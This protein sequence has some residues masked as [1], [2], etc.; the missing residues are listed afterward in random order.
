MPELRAAIVALRRTFLTAGLFSL[1]INALMLVPSLY[2]L[3]VYDRVLTSRNEMTLLMVTLVM[4]LAYALLGIFEWVRAQLLIGASNQL[5]DQVG[6]R[7][8]TATFQ[9]TLRG[10]NGNPAQS[11]TDLSTVRQFLSGAGLLAFFDA[12]WM[13]I[14]LIVLTLL[15]PLLGLLALVGG[16]VLII[17]TFITERI[18]QEPLSQANTLA[19]QANT[20]AGNSLRNAE[21]I[22]AM[23]MLGALRAHWRRRHEKSLALQ[24]LASSRAGSIGAVTRFTRISLQ[25]LALGLGAWLVVKDELGAGS[26]IVASILTGRALSPIEQVIGAWRN[27]VGARSAYDRLSTLLK[28]FPAVAPAMPLPRPVGAVSVEAVSAVAPNTQTVI[29]RGINFSVAPAEIVA[30]IGPSASGKSSLARLLVGVWPAAAGKVRLD[31]ADIHAWNKLELGRHVG[32]LPQDVELFEGSV[33][34]NIARFNTP[35]SEATVQAAQ[36]AGIHDMILRLPKGYE[37]E[38]GIGG[39]HLSGGQRQRIGLARA[40]YGDPA[41]VVLD[42]PNANLDETGE[43]AL[44][45]AM[46]DLTAGG[47][48]V[49]VVAHRSN[50]VAVADKLLVLRDGMQHAFGPRADVIG[51]LNRAAQAAA[52]AKGAPEPASAATPS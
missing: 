8:F 28:N 6:N 51:A 44:V 20:F 1:F 49:L 43:L 45:K 26:M 38:I 39:S 31:G 7:V 11:L 25:S 24:Q 30:I 52:A 13:P 34:D 27:L 9:A 12:P 10:A 18:T 2:M 35:D 3:Q 16:I 47:S 50:I 36:R 17:L 22:E 33:A 19:V 42:E 40:M 32:Y 15:H 14:Y 48:T 41:L 37:T 4:F 23:G 21:V 46:Q 5:D 29:L